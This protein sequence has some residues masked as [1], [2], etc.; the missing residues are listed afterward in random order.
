M[1][2][3]SFD[4]NNMMADRIGK[5]YGISQEEI[6]A[7]AAQCEAAFSKMTQN[8]WAFMELPYNSGLVKEIDK[9]AKD[10]A[11]RFKN[12]VVIGIG[13]SALG[14]RTLHNALPP[15]KDRPRIFILDNVDPD[16]ISKLINTI[17]FKHTLFNV[18]S[19]SGNTA[20]TMANFMVLRKHL[21]D[22]V[23]YKK[24]KRHIIATTDPGKSTLRQIAQSEGYRILE[25]PPRVGGRFSVLSSVGLFSAAFGG[26]DVGELLEGARYM[27]EVCKQ[28]DIWRNPGC[29]ST[30]LQ[31]L[32]YKKGRSICVFMPYSDRLK[33]LAEW[34]SQL[35]AESLGK[36]AD[37]GSTPVKALGVTDQH[38]QLQLYMEG[39]QDK[40]IVFVKVKEF[41]D[42]VHI[43]SD[44]QQYSKVGYL[45]GHSLNELIT[46]EQRG[47]ELALTKSMRPN[48]TITLDSIT[49][50]T[51]GGLMYMLEVQTA[52]IGELFKI[53]AFNQPG[54][55]LSKQLTSA[56]LGRPGYEEKREEIEKLPKWRD[57]YC[58]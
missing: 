46:A 48:C 37:I 55:E 35:W 17:D 26:I 50:F 4:F 16:T 18:I 25:I 20:E 14:N 31:Y 13:G 27:D 7:L 12:L 42:T 15:E 6:E 39:P 33:Y 5:E 8:N 29:M 9:L 40:V 45:G 24:H 58:I 22:K 21:I 53:D 57:K 34:Y 10:A 1:K 28:R 41:S 32:F 19:K 30:V 36:T 38:S 56:L 52:F 49:P 54:V 43:P 2:G 11:K 23:G 47:T 3:I 44:F 51:I